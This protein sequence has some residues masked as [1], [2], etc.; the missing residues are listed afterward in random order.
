LR[1]HLIFKIR[2]RHGYIVNKYNSIDWRTSL[3]PAPAVIP[4]PRVYVNIV[5][6]KTLVVCLRN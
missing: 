5:V 2:I 4:A 1:V 6:V 3:V